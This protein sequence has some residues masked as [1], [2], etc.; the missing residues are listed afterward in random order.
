[1]GQISS[2]KSLP[3]S[4]Y[5]TKRKQ[6]WVLTPGLSLSPGLT[7]TSVGYMSQTLRALKH[8]A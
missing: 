3:V 1:M 4:M 5:Y 2:Y 8:L 6:T 7:Q